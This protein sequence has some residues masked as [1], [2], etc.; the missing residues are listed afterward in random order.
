MIHWAG[1]FKP[2]TRAQVHT[3]L[4]SARSQCLPREPQT[5]QGTS[6][7]DPA[8]TPPFPP[9]MI[10]CSPSCRCPDGKCLPARSGGCS[11]ARSPH[12]CRCRRSRASKPG[13]HIRKSTGLGG[14]RGPGGAARAVR[15]AAR[16]AGCSGL[17][18]PASWCRAQG[19][20]RRPPGLVSGAGTEG[21][22]D[23]HTWPGTARS[24]Q[25]RSPVRGAL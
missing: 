23:A 20:A 15:A 25:L 8:P 10:G 17:R 18:T 2:Q 6:A 4:P 24:L 1:K 5:F 22:T 16:R 14:L 13:S 12:G 7:H 11:H 9:G 3:F 19:R 21:P